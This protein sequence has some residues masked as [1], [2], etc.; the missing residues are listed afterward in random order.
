MDEPMM[1][2]LGL[3]LV[4]ALGSAFASWVT[5][6]PPLLSNARMQWAFAFAVVT[7]AAILCA[8]LVLKGYARAP[9]IAVA[10][11]STSIG[12]RRWRLV[13]VAGER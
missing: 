6:D 11:V 9:W 3:P 2:T 5:L 7:E 1:I 13:V 10:W 4:L 8:L 12:L